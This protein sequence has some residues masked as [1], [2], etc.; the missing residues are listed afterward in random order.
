MPKYLVHGSYTPE[1]MKGLLKEGGTGRRDATTRA[2]ESVGG[3]VEMVYYAFG[4]DDF[5]IV[6]EFPDNVSAAT[7]A[8]AAAGSG[9]INSQMVVLL[10]PEEIDEAT[11]RAVRYRAPGE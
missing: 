11:K 10:T 9:A 3:R 6:A 7:V 1:G 8:M 2:V 4:K 5:Y